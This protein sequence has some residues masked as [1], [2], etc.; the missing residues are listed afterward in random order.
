MIEIQRAIKKI[1]ERY[2]AQ[3]IP[4]TQNASAGDN[5]VYIESTRRFNEGDYVVIRP[6][7][8]INT[9][10]KEDVE[11]L[12]ISRIPDH[13]TLV[14][15]DDLTQSYEYS[16]S[17]VQKLIG[18]EAGNADFLKAVYIGDP[19]V[20]TQFPSIT[21]DAKTRNSSWLTLE[22]TSEEYQIDVTVY[23]DAQAHYDSQYELMHLYVK[24]IERALM[25]SLYPLVQPYKSTT[26]ATDV[27]PTDDVIRV[28]D[29]NFYQCGMGWI[30]LESVDYLVPN[31]AIE[32]LGN[33]ALQ[34]VRAVGSPFTAGDT[35]IHPLRH[36]YDSLPYSTRYGTVNKGA[37]LKAAVISWRCKEEV[38]RYQ[39]Y[40]DPLTF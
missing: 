8:L 28:N 12:C 25:R 5:T 38:R 10:E 11:V 24:S 33:G 36:I 31:R 16:N 39:P 7:D 20:I 18:Y 35:V 6:L 22:S 30:F 40:I 13:N 37:M 32:H 9:D 14:F 27:D 2:I 29:E 1:I 34:L 3:M 4:M 17:I 26:L 19:A 15:S 23:V 21:I